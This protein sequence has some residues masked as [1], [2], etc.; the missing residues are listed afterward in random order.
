[1]AVP[2]IDSVVIAARWPDRIREWMPE[3]VAQLEDPRVVRL[4]RVLSQVIDGDAPGDPLLE[5]AADIMAAPAEEAFAA[6]EVIRRR[7]RTIWRSTCSTRWPLR[8]TRG[9]S[10]FAS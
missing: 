6:G 1:M 7:K 9:R 8:P 2:D 4:C 10:G 3:K 5:E